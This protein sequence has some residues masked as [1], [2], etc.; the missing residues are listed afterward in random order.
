VS[1][2]TIGRRWIRWV[3]KSCTAILATFN[4]RG[5]PFRSGSWL[6]MLCLIGCQVFRQTALDRHHIQHV[7]HIVQFRKLIVQNYSQK[8][9]V[10]LDFPVI[11]N[12]A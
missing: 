2:A 12:E 3:S 6:G 11:V 9:R 7:D 4:L 10:D 5:T 8:G 1:Q